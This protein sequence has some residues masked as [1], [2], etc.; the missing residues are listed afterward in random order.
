M[1]SLLSKTSWDVIDPGSLIPLVG[2][3][4]MTTEFGYLL[5]HYWIPD[6][7]LQFQ[8][9]TEQSTPGQEPVISRQMIQRTMVRCD[10]DCC[11][12]REKILASDAGHEQLILPSNPVAPVTQ[13]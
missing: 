4:T 9:T 13:K 6:T 7:R 12:W 2:F 5:R 1:P 3:R 11:V 8:V 10:A